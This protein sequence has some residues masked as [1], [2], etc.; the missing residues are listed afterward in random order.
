MQNY[1]KNFVIVKF[2]KFIAGIIK[3]D[4]ISFKGFFDGRYCMYVVVGI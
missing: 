2:N 3:M 4:Y 1:A